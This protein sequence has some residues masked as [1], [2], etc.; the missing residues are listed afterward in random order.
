[1][2]NLFSDEKVNT[3]RQVELDIA[4]AL[5]IIF[6]IF[7]HTLMVVKGF[8][9]SLSPAYDYIFSN[10][11]GRPCA[12]PVFMF[13]MGVGIVYSRR[14]LWNIMIKRG[15]TLYILGLLVNIFEFFLPGFLCGTL[16]GKW[17][18]F[19]MDGGLLLFCVD[20]LAFAGSAFILLGI[21]KKFNISNKWLIVIAVVM[22]LIGTFSRGTD[23]G[24]PI[25]NLLFADF[26]GSTG[27]FGAFPLFVWFIFPVA[28]YI[29]AQYFI[30]AKDKGQ[31]F[32][33]WPIYII[34]AFIYFFITSHVLGSGVFSDD[35][36]LY[37]FMTT[38]DAIFCII[39]AHGN[40]GFCYWLVKYL[41][42]KII[43]AFSILSSNI[44][45]IYIAQWCFIPLGVIFLV[46]IFRDLVFTDVISTIYAICMLILATAFAIYY[47]KLRTG[48]N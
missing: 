5:S 7:L 17:N 12:A 44:N 31:F 9:H 33:F 48:K 40:I 10:V 23:F 24:S 3:G 29:W 6:M 20:I 46:Y 36:H 18:V 47:K 39:Y 22:S 1:M 21:L 11:L 19:P 45:T 41:P 38:L 25:L 34:V 2:S 8:D 43:K 27:G 4:K 28:G 30:R 32:R 13:C 26:I 37:Y 16:F 35:V 42:D 15:I 14:S